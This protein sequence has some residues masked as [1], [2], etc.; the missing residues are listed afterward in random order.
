MHL[1]ALAGKLL[2]FPTIFPL[3]VSL[4][5]FPFFSPLSCLSP[6]LCSFYLGIYFWVTFSRVLSHNS[7]RVVSAL[8]QWT[9]S[10]ERSAERA[11]ASRYCSSVL[12][13]T[14][15]L[16]AVAPWKLPL[17]SWI[18][19]H[20]LFDPI[21]FLNSTTLWRIY[22]R[23]DAVRSALLAVAHFPLSLSLFLKGKKNLCHLSLSV[24]FSIRECSLKRPM[25]SFQ[26]VP[27][28]IIGN[29]CIYNSDCDQSRNS[30]RYFFLLSH[31]HRLVVIF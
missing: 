1:Y 7:G 2:L 15:F 25:R 17:S 20:R 26:S 28:S 8:R 11:P 29:K 3:S 16:I 27:I 31:E 10:S 23:S 30:P 6:S 22:R 5:F 13:V 24:R 4:P 9:T 12:P 21:R 18:L 19:L 14:F